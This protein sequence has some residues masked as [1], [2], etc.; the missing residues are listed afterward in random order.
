M[1]NI[2]IFEYTVLSIP[3]HSNVTLAG[4]SVFR[5]LSSTCLLFSE[6]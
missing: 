6:H 5:A 2:A 4:K 1:Y 3:F